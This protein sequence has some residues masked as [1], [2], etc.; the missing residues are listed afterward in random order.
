[1]N[2]TIEKHQ[3][4]ECGCSKT[5]AGER[6]ENACEALIIDNPSTQPYNS[7][8]MTARKAESAV[9]FQTQ[10]RNLHREFRPVVLR[11]LKRLVNDT[12]AE[13]LCQE[14]F[15]RVN[16][17]LG[18]F[19]GR[20]QWSTWIYRIAT[21]LAID[22]MRTPAARNGKRT[23]ALKDS[24]E[25]K[26]C[27]A[28]T[29]EE[30]QS[31]EVNMLMNEMWDCFREH[32]DRLPPS[33]RTVFVLSELEGLANAKI[34]AVLEVSLHTVKIRLHRAREKLFQELR[35]NCQPEEWAYELFEK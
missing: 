22:H 8:A 4:E 13:D 34:A 18:K 15:L 10:F 19:Q 28:W 21:N 27:N 12:E 2:P 11:Y 5:I 17:S 32:I 6:G 25:P 24:P 1:M 9:A 33:Q 20:S 3:S 30:A 31:P 23:A 7:F 16:R 29:G 26:A 35:A 14:V